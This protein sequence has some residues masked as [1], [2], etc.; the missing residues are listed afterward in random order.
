MANEL[1]LA[2]GTFDL[3]HEGHKFFLR[4][5]KEQ[6]KQLVVVVARDKSVE[7]I[8]SFPPTQDEGQRLEAVRK[9]DFVDNVVL[10]KE[11]DYRYEIVKEINPDVIVMGYDQE[12]SEE[13][14]IA[15]LEKI[16][17]NAKVVRLEPFKEHE[18]KSSKIRKNNN[19]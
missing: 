4:K 5:A 3:L 13:E 17:V 12:P 14:L 18:F 19:F 10:G 8:K 1:V 15:M 7:K 2:F 9:L 11:I 16:N 6:G